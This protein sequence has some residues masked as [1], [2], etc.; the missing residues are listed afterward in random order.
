M[1]TVVPEVLK[2][3]ARVGRREE[4]V[5][6]I[7]TKRATGSEN[8]EGWSRNVKRTGA[9]R[10]RDGLL[11]ELLVTFFWLLGWVRPRQG[12][13]VTVPTWETRIGSPPKRKFCCAL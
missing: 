8:E 12:V 3:G 11:E 10:G 2:T 13:T 1:S 5:A 7:E 9:G 6:M 4:E